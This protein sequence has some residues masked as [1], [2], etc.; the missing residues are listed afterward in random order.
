MHYLLFILLAPLL[1]LQG[2]RVKRITP[3][4]PEAAGPRAGISGEG[5]DLSLLV[6]GDSAAAGVGVDDQQQALIGVL[7]QALACEYRVDWRLLAKSGYNTAQ[8]MRMLQTEVDS[9]SN[10]GFDVVVVSLGVNDVLSPL[11][12]KRWIAQQKALVELLTV[13]LGCQTLVLTR[14]P[15]MGDFPIL[16]QPLR[17]FLGR[18]SQEF[19]QHLEQFA[20][21]EPRFTLLNFGQQLDAEAMATDGFHPGKLIY[22][23]WGQSA[24]KVVL[25]NKPKAN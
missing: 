14:V 1:F 18:R 9:Q 7:A 5:S 4:L 22:R 23:D 8:A 3:K 24:A 13:E 16:P 15:P 20:K 25:L 21:Q 19:N 11:S 17:W 12:V 10:L 2:K 6:F